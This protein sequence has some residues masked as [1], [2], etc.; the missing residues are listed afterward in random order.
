PPWGTSAGGTRVTIEGAF[1]VD[2]RVAFGDATAPVLEANPTTL[3]VETPPNVPGPVA[4]RVSREARFGLLDDAFTY[5]ADR[6]DRVGL[7]GEIRR[8]ALIGGYWA[9]SETD[10]GRARLAFV[11]LADWTL[12]EDYGTP[13]ACTWG[14][15]P[16]LPQAIDTGAVS[17]GLASTRGAT[18]PLSPLP[19]DGWFEAS[20]LDAQVAPGTAFDLE[21]VMAP[22]PWPPFGLAG[23]ATLPPAF[24]VVAPAIRDV[25]PPLVSRDFSLQWDGQSGDFMVLHLIRAYEPGGVL[26]AVDDMRCTFPDTG[27]FTV[28]G[29]LWPDWFSG[30]LMFIRLGRAVTTS[31]RL[32]HDDAL[33]RVAAVHFVIGAAETAN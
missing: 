3:V 27:R 29:S 1:P 33:A 12:A 2:V 16:A 4:V 9:A 30:D 6:S 22:A 26:T 7:I 11:D 18:I 10:D 21:T 25:Q 31:R 15:T 17:L 28:D 23:L 8:E 14:L 19:E 20:L 32:P 24:G 5:Y 13:G